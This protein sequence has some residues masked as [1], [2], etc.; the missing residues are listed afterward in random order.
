MAAVDGAA[1]VTVIIAAAVEWGQEVALVGAADSQVHL[2][3]SH[4]LLL[5]LPLPLLLC[6][7]LPLLLQLSGARRLRWWVLMTALATGMLRSP[8]P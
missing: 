6:S 4:I 5:A 1:T 2:L 7:P 8:S 3:L